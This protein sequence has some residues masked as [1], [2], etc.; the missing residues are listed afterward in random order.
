M[1]LMD[2]TDNHAGVGQYEMEVRLSR[3]FGIPAPTTNPYHN[4]W[5]TRVAKQISR[6]LQRSEQKEQRREFR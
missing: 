2:Y 4:K 1:N 6:M 5:T 3:K